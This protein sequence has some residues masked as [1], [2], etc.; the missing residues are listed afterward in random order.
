MV[1]DATRRSI[2]WPKAPK[3]LSS[4]LRR[5]ALTLRA[6]GI[7]LQFGRGNEQGRRMV[8]VL[9]TRAGPKK[10]SVIVN[11]RAEEG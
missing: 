3:G 6:A 11:N 2:R 9:P 7:E 8:S 5:I 4:A 1:S 10:S